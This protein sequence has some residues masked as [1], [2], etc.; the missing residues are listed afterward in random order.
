MGNASRW[1]KA[2]LE[3]VAEMFPVGTPDDDALSHCENM[4]Y[5]IHG[6]EPVG[7]DASVHDIVS[8]WSDGEDSRYD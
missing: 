5:D 8:W 4:H 3:L 7:A 2:Q 1:C 6:D